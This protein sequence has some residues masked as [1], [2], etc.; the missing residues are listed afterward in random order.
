V[1]ESLSSS[2]SHFAPWGHFPIL[3]N[4][5]TEF[6]HAKGLYLVKEKWVR[7]DLSARVYHDRLEF[8]KPQIRP[9]LVLGYIEELEVR[10]RL[11]KGSV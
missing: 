2:P 4:N 11:L 5:K 7:S 3:Y 9:V 8:G 10:T 6:V 1:V